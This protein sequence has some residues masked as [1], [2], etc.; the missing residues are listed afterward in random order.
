M[1]WLLLLVPAAVT[2][3]VLLGQIDEEPSVEVLDLLDRLERESGVESEAYLYLMGLSAAEGVD[4]Q[5]AGRQHLMT[6]E[7]A[8]EDDVAASLIAERSL[9]ALPRPDGELFCSVR[10]KCCL[11]RLVNADIDIARL[12]EKHAVL[13]DRAN[14]FYQYTEYTT[15]VKPTLE[16]RYPPYQLLSAA[17]RLKSLQALAVYRQGD[18]DQA[19]GLLRQ[20]LAA[21]RRAMVYQDSLVGKLVFLMKISEVLDIYSVILASEGHEAEVILPLT[22]S[23]KDFSI[24][25]AREFGLSHGILSNLDRHPEIFELKGSLPGWMVRLL[26]KPNMTLNAIAPLYHRLEM[27]TSMSA[28]EFSRVVNSK[29]RASIATSWIRNAVGSVLAREM[30]SYDEY[31]ARFHDVDAKIA[32][33]NHRYQAGSRT[34]EVSNPY[35]GSE[36]PSFSAGSLCLNGP[37]EDKNFLRC[38]R[39][40]P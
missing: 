40:A 26:Y 16:E 29:A 24:V 38:L 12:L 36:P 5:E 27:L 37:M 4:P 22:D 18:V 23:E 32:L 8:A 20:Q 30:T 6:R 17:E 25:V 31:A 1:K 34:D 13:L 14:R 19:G 35:Y 15:L 9:D 11:Q 7:R 39:V 10:E 21:L 2:G 28:A 33:F 3:L